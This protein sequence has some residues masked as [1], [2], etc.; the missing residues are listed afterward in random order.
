MIYNRSVCSKFAT[1]A[2]VLQRYTRAFLIL[3]ACLATF[4][5]V[6]SDEPVE[7]IDYLENPEYLDDW[8][9]EVG[10]KM[11]DFALTDSTGQLR[12]LDSLTNSS[13]LILF[14]T[15]SADW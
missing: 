4:V 6:A 8:G 3:F 7:P 2:G 15:R 9:P 13:G 10:S 5:A 1:M 12:D 14:L 11:P